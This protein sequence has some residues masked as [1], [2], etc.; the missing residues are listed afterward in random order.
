MDVIRLKVRKQGTALFIGSAT[1][2]DRTLITC[3]YTTRVGAKIAAL[4]AVQ[5][6]LATEVADELM[7]VK[8]KIER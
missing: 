5:A 8:P 3:P 2:G 4:G 1:I 7:R 6:W